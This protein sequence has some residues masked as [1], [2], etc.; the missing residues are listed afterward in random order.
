MVVKVGAV[1]ERLNL[2][3]WEHLREWK[4]HKMQ[5]E[6]LKKLICRAVWKRASKQLPYA[7]SHLRC[8]YSSVQCGRLFTVTGRGR[9]RLTS[10]IVKGLRGVSHPPG[11]GITDVCPMAKLYVIVYLLENKGYK[12]VHILM[13]ICTNDEF[14]IKSP[15]LS[16]WNFKLVLMRPFSF[17][18]FILRGHD[19]S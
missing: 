12:N 14:K 19:T 5:R 8:D 3:G 9:Q 17:R 4:H 16:V 10:P 2:M 6:E 7:W 11:N 13:L 15:I 18:L 1:P